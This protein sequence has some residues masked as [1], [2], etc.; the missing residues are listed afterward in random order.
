[1]QMKVREKIKF[2]DLNNAALCK[3][4]LEVVFK[5]G[6]GCKKR[7]R[8]RR[9]PTVVIVMLVAMIIAASVIAG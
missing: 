2:R 5:E 9:D 3:M 4:S 8:K 6:L 1:M 7:Q